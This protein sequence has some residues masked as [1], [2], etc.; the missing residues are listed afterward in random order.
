MISASYRSQVLVFSIVLYV[1]DDWQHVDSLSTAIYMCVVTVTTVGYG[2]ITPQT[3]PA[4]VVSGCLCFISVLFMAMPL[5]VVGNAMSETWSDRHRILLVARARQRL[6]VWG[7]SADA[8]G[9]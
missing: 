6:K 2:D 5:S 7:I 1:V 9:P 8:A 3:W 4:K